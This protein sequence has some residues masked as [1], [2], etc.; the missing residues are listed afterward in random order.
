MWL[1]SNQST[2]WAGQRGI[3]FDYKPLINKSK[4]KRGRETLNRLL[5]SAAQVFYEKGYHNASIND[6]TRF[7]GVDSGTFYLYFD[8]KYNLYKFLGLNWG[9]C[10][11]HPT[12]LNQAVE[13]D[14]NILTGGIFTEEGASPPDLTPLPIPIQVELE[15]DE[16]L[17]EESM[18]F[19]A[20]DR[21][22]PSPALP[23]E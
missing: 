4:A 15:D 8:G 19:E 6:I 12:N 10:I 1:Y 7:S 14:M 17:E 18:E 21:F 2:G 20:K 9:L 5:S 22:D 3:G 11:D 16:A 23:K 13:S